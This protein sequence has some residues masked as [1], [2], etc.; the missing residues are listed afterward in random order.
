MSTY[1]VV[2]CTAE[3][4]RFFVTMVNHYKNTGVV[5]YEKRNSHV[6]PLPMFKNI[7]RARK[8][9]LLSDRKI[10]HISKFYN[11]FHIVVTNIPVSCEFVP[12]S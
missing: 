4:S 10:L 1:N 3:Y 12:I 8:I 11:A 6:H 5:C 2:D 9:I 7:L